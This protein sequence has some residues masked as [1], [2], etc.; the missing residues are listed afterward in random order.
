M[1]KKLFC[2]ALSMVVLVGNM[3]TGIGVYALDNESQN[4]ESENLSRDNRAVL[5]KALL[6]IGDY[7][8][9]NEKLIKSFCMDYELSDEIDKII[10]SDDEIAV[11]S[12]DAGASNTDTANVSLEKAFNEGKLLLSS[13]F[14][15]K[16]N[17]EI[18]L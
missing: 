12:Y 10:E 9:E 16:A 5:K 17:R 15:E 2:M 11:L 1:K 14:E 7:Y 6:N 3:D 13:A 18:Q 4:N 8:N